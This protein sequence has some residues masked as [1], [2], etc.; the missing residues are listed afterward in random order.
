[1]FFNHQ[2]YFRYG[3]FILPILT[4]KGV[5]Q[6]EHLILKMILIKDIFIAAGMHIQYLKWLQLPWQNCESALL[7]FL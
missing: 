7:F 6:S 4:A 1:M 5:A 3:L 2:I